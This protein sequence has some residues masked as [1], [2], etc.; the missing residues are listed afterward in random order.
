MAE[1]IDQQRL[2][3][4]HAHPDDETIGTGATIAHYVA[5]GAQVTVLTCTLGEWGE[6]LVPELAELEATRGDQLGGYR[7][8]EM[9]AAMTA[10]GV[11]D[12][13]YL[14]AP[15]RYRDSGMIGTSANS[16]P[17]AFWRG[18]TDSEVFDAAV[19]DL[20]T[21]IRDVRP[22]VVVTYNP[23]GG[24]GHPDHMMAHRVSTEAVRRAAD[25]GHRPDLGA[26][27]TVSKF[28]WT[29]RPTSVLAGQL[30]ELRAMPG[31]YDVP[32]DA[33]EL[34]SDE[35]ALVTSRVDASEQTSAKVAAMRCHATQLLVAE[36]RFALSN[37]V[38][39]QL[40]GVEYYRLVTGPGGP[41]DA[42]GFEFDLFGGLQ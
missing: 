13:R 9:A 2:L 14:G 26:E 33:A 18:A 41:R 15:G 12:H 23:G 5:A 31:P 27:W 10:L 39:Q 25:P 20:L 29:A 6:I 24:Y 32:V 7:M 35:D 8:G 37:R 3:L 28:Y 22:Q 40:T 1:G 16:D 21:V 4:V 11:V 34:P 42:A 36:D 19:D 30:D 17:R 38:A